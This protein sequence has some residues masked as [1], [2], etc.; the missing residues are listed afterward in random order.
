MVNRIINASLIT[1]QLLI[2]HQLKFPLKRTRLRLKIIIVN[3][4]ALVTCVDDRV[5]LKNIVLQAWNCYL[6]LT[7]NTE[8]DW[9]CVCVCVCVKEREVSTR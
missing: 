4:I 7:L 1:Q 3:N 6:S 8:K 2:G 9:L 5:N